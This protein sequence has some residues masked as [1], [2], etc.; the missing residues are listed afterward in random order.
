M[1]EAE[2]WKQAYSELEKAVNEKDNEIL[3]VAGRERQINTRMD[4]HTFSLHGCP[5]PVS[6]EPLVS[7]FVNMLQY[8]HIYTH[9][10]TS[11]Q[12]LAKL[13]L[14][15]TKKQHKSLKGCKKA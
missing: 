14:N 5:S 13:C 7:T 6:K 9:T 10:H 12:N 3:Q 11:Q 1:N 15:A 8:P 2:K 4:C